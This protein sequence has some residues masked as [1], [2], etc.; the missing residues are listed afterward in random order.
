MD[1]DEKSSQIRIMPFI[2][3][4]AET[5]VVWLGSG[6]GFKP[7]ESVYWE[8]L[9]VIQEFGMARRLMICWGEMSD[10]RPYGLGFDCTTFVFPWD[11]FFPTVGPHAIDTSLL[12]LNADVLKFKRLRET[13]YLG[14]RLLRILLRDHQDATCKDLRDKVYGLVGL[15]TDCFRRLPVDYRKT[16]WEVYKD[17]VTFYMLDPEILELSKLLRTLIGGPD[18]IPRWVLEE[19]KKTLKRVLDPADPMT[20]KLPTFFL[21]T[22]VYLGP[23]YNEIMSS[24]EHVS[25][26]EAAIERVVSKPGLGQHL[27]QSDLFLEDLEGI[28]EEALKA[29]LSPSQ[30]IIWRYLDDCEENDLLVYRVE[31]MAK[32]PTNEHTQTSSRLFLIHG[33]GADVSGTPIGFACKG[34]GPGD[35]V[36]QVPNYELAMVR[37]ASRTIMMGS[38]RIKILNGSSSL[39]SHPNAHN[40][41]LALSN[42]SSA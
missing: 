38:K 27:E 26:W 18:N 6:I 21:G 35:L 33:K 5:V 20:V 16:L 8:R 3:K 1:T 34:A 40:E 22:I 13:K 14:N 17:V 42:L 25:D 19:G 31:S 4:R 37:L 36:F 10:H 11:E 15:S 41:T 30:T 23:T 29:R 28:S 9:W 24:F 39:T 2:Y 7:N 32:L 12:P